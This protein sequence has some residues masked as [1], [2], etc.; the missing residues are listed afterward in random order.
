M[1]LLI[2]VYSPIEELMRINQDSWDHPHVEG[3]KTLY[4]FEGEH[5]FA[6][7]IP[8]GWELSLP[9]ATLERALLAAKNMGIQHDRYIEVN[10]KDSPDKEKLLHGS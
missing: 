1:K 8:S 4:Y 3:V 9:D 5:Y 7:I 6:R 10:E 2:I